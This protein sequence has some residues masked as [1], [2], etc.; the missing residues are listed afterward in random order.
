MEAQL[1]SRVTRVIKMNRQINEINVTIIFLYRHLKALK[2]LN[3][4]QSSNT[5]FQFG[6]NS[7][8]NEV[9][10]NA[11]FYLHS[12]Q[13]DKELLFNYKRKYGRLQYYS[14]LQADRRCQLKSNQHQEPLLSNRTKIDYHC[15]MMF[16]MFCKYN[17]NSFI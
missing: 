9:K 13:D 11:E 16:N 12:N 2:T 10:L 5:H 3:A 1:Q 6:S 14:D 15:T 4:T 17:L 7:M 8:T